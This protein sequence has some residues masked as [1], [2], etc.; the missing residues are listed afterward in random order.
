M[1][2]DSYSMRNDIIYTR[3]ENLERMIR[4]KKIIPYQIRP[5]DKYIKGKWY[6]NFEFGEIFKVL[7]VEYIHGV[8]L[9]HVCTKSLD[10]HYSYLCTDLSTEDYQIAFDSNEIYKQNIFEE[11]RTYT[12][13]EIRYW[14]F[15]NNI[16]GFDKK[17]SVFWDYVDTFS[18]RRLKDTSRYIIK[19]KIENGIYT[20]AK[21]IKIPEKNKECTK[22]DKNYIKF[23]K[24]LKDQNMKSMMEIK[25]P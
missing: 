15:M 25:K 18:K 1:K 16:H 24:D 7:E 19:S 10:N 11:K 9:D 13:A 14:F 12:G 6:Y 20:E 5:N 21:I 4:S 17:Y 3:T 8:V 22:N 2:G 23:M